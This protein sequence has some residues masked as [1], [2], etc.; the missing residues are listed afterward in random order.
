MTLN[1]NHISGIHNYCD[2]WCE[3]CTFTSRCAVFAS[4]QNLS[5]EEN[6]ISNKAFWNN[7]AN[8]FADAIELLHK[9]A[10]EH[11]VDLNNLE[12]E[13][14]KA[15][16]AKREKNREDIKQ[17]PLIKYCTEYMMDARVLLK[18]HKAFKDK[19]A[20]DVQ[21]IELGLKDLTET[22]N[23]YS[24]LNDNLEII[25]WYLFQINVKFTRAFS[26]FEEDDEYGFSKDDS[27][28][29]AK[30]ALIA[31]ERC[32]A[33]WQNIIHLMPALQDEVIPLLALLQ[34]IKRLGLVTFPHAMAFI[35]PGLD[36]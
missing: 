1:P 3:R 15:Y 36:E 21:L 35:R 30:V 23:T 8:T 7:I 27:N 11:G 34:K 10:A 16:E 26:S 5:P 32:L 22:K 28:G 24:T 18:T 29:S 13:E 2:K 25:Q 20:S 9:A 6:D 19:A 12:N 14:M 31:T 17:H 33:A 4:E